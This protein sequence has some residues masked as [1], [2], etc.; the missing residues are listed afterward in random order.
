MAQRCSYCGKTEK[1]HGGKACVDV[2]GFRIARLEA[3]L[4]AA[5][6][7]ARHIQFSRD[8]LDAANDRIDELER[9]HE[10]LR[11]ELA[12]ARRELGEAREDTRRLDWLVANGARDRAAIDLIL[13]GS[14]KQAALLAELPGLPVAEMLDRGWLSPVSDIGD[15]Y[16]EDALCRFFEVNSRAELKDLLYGD[17]G[18]A[19]AATREVPHAG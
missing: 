1:Q 17:F 19:I 8:E 18:A 6:E 12:E 7:R 2:A 3:D 5:N 11:A 10:A 14:T 4:H 9:A 13:A 15:P 16:L